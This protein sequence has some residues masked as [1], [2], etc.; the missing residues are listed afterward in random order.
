MFADL[1]LPLSDHSIVLLDL[2]CSPPPPPP[3]SGWTEF[4]FY[5]TTRRE[6]VAEE[7]EINLLLVDLSSRFPP[8]PMIGVHKRGQRLQERCQREIAASSSTN[9]C[10]TLWKKQPRDHR[11]HPNI[12][13]KHRFE[14]FQVP[15][16]HP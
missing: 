2:V 4:R 1:L 5:E 14:K 3:P 15:G 8:S 12:I 13:G 11:Y 10:M 16:M 9:L 7:G 6:G